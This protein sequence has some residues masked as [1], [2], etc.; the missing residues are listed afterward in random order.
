MGF[1]K[2][3]RKI[4]ESIRDRWHCL[5]FF[6]YGQGRSVAELGEEALRGKST[7][8][9]ICKFKDVCNRRHHLR[10]D[11][12]F[13]QMAAIT[14]QAVALSQ[15]N[16]TDVVE[17]VVTAVTRAAELEIEEALE[18]KAILK[19]FEVE[20]MTDHYRAG[21]FE[22]IQDGLDKKR[23]PGKSPSADGEA[24]RAS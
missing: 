17:E 22:N 14:A 10:M 12:R 2:V 21:Q 16:G 7:C 23:L 11:R 6:G 8:F 18:V 4:R 3:R 15:R 20:S 9:D 1:N 19:R 24:K 5:G 13:P